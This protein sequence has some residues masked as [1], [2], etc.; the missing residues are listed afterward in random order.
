[1]DVDTAEGVTD[2]VPAEKAF[3]VLGNPIRVDVLR[4]LGDAADPL[5]FSTLYDRVDVDDSGQF[6]YH[7]DKLVGHFVRKTDDGYALAR[8]GRRVVEAVLA[9]TVTGE[10]RLERTPV[11]DT[12]EYCGSTLTVEWRAGSVELYCTGCAGRYRRTHGGKPRGHDADSGYLGRLFL[13]PAG[14]ADRDP[15]A[16]LDAAWRWTMSE[17]QALAG[18]I[19]PR[20]SAAIDRTVL[21]CS[22]HETDECQC[23]N[24]DREHAVGVRFDCSNC[25]LRTGGSAVL[26]LATETELLAFLTDHGLNPLAP[27]AIGRL[28]ETY[29]SYDEELHTTDPLDARF[30]FT[31]DGDSLTLRVDGDLSVVEATRDGSSR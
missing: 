24:C 27:D 7:L 15:D 17:V 25:I 23:P 19:C 6:N 26:A 22:D 21:V 9:G 28:N 3:G 31:A 5:A 30:T 13:P 11:D 2:A 1:M 18:G 20:C 4:V 12:C 14:L 29:Q 16:V 8:P 10:A